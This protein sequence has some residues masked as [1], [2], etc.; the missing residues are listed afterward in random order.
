M[1]YIQ[2]N[3][4]KVLKQAQIDI[5]TICNIHYNYNEFDPKFKVKNLKLVKNVKFCHSFLSQ[6]NIT[7]TVL[8]FVL[9]LIIQF[10]SP[11]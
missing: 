10:S 5:H 3:L 4:N 9:R 8:G 6:K 7:E 11:K 2:H 1:N